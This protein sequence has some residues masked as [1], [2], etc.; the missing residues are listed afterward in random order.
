MSIELIKITTK[1]E[2]RVVGI[3]CPLSPA[4]AS[5]VWHRF[6]QRV[7]EISNRTDSQ[8]CLGICNDL[9]QQ[10]IACVEVNSFEIIPEGMVSLVVPRNEYAIF[11]HRGSILRIR[12]SFQE[13]GTWL[14]ENNYRG[15]N[16][17][18]FFELYDEKYKGESDDSELYIY[19]VLVKN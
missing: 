2:F 9:N 15:M 11:K 7:N 10:Y 8:I 5:K 16:K 18:P 4:E 1:E 19:M 6:I 13:I 12:E 3:E 14:F 17:P